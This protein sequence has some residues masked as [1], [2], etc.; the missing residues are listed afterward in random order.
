MPPN[1]LLHFLHYFSLLKFLISRL[2][3]L[4]PFLALC[5][6]NRGYTP[7][8]IF[9]CIATYHHRWDCS[10]VS[11]KLCVNIFITTCQFANSMCVHAYVIKTTTCNT[12]STS[13]MKV[14]SVWWVCVSVCLFVCVTWSDV[15]CVLRSGAVRPVPR[16]RQDSQP[17]QVLQ[18]RLRWV[19]PTVMLI[20]LDV[21]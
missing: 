13:I 3:T 12:L 10:Q 11:N 1:C 5:V 4:N 20:G 19:T 16:R 21:G 7:Y 14:W 2:L 9:G 18:P 8:Y 15:C 6:F 17:Q